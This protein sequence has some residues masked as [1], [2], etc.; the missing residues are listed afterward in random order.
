MDEIVDDASGK[1]EY[2]CNDSSFCAAR[3]PRSAP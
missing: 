1:A 2:Q 3:A